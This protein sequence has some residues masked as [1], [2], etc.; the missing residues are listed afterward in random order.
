[1]IITKLYGGLGNQMFQYAAG[2][3]LAKRLGTTVSV[4]ESWYADQKRLGVRTIRQYE[5]EIL[6]I[7]PQKQGVLAKLNLKLSPPAVFKDR[8]QGYDKEFEQLK[9][10]IILD[11][12]WQSYRYF[13]HAAKEVRRAFRFPEEISKQNSRLLDDINKSESVSIHVRRADYASDPYNK[14]FLGALSLDYYKQAIKS[15]NVVKEDMCFYVFSDDIDWCKKNIKLGPR[16]TF[17]SHNFGPRSFEDMR[18][19]AACKHNIVA[20]S[21]FSWWG[22]WLNDNPSKLVIAPKKWFNIPGFK[23]EDIVLDTWTKI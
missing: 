20:N 21:S 5:L 18:L 23:T 11:G 8:E 1:M 9:D 6:G 13:E 22:A 19:M 7:Y 10:N 3:G 14:K 12:H 16:A 2:L 4:D 17:I 15:M